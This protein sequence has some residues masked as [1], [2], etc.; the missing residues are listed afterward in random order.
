MKTFFSTHVEKKKLGLKPATHQELKRTILKLPEV[1]KAG[2]RWS[3]KNYPNGYTSYGSLSNLHEQFSIFNELKI[4]LDREATKFAR[5]V[6]MEFPKGELLLSSLWANVMP[7]HCY[8]AFHL[9][10]N[11]VVSGTYYVSI[12]EGAS[13]LRIE[14]PRTA[15]LMACPPRKIQQDLIPKEGEV[16][17]FES[18][19]KHEV[20]PHFCSE[21]RI[22]ISF[23]YDWIRA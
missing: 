18:W 9:H 22:S 3:A 14:D 7:K 8:H 19:M 1:D 5:A 11:S 17:L 13:P 4:L 12:P 20:P 2:V 23:N 15:M 10:P 16:I 21:P 6:G